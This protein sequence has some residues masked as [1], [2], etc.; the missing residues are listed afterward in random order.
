MPSSLVSS[1]QGRPA[2]E[3]GSRSCVGQPQFWQRLPMLLQTT[4]SLFPNIVPQV[5][6]FS[7]AQVQW[8]ISSLPENDR[9]WERYRGHQ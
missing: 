4:P 6:L 5:L 2:S 7:Q 3:A 1:L 8:D 9:S